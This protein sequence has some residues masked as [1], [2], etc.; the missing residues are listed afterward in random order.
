MAEH[1]S[2]MLV[3]ADD[4]GRHPSSCQ[5]LTR[6]LLD[7]HAVCWVN[8]IGTRKPKLDLATLLRGVEKVKQWAWKSRKTEAL[9]AN[10]RVVNP[11]MWPWISRR[12]DRWL[13]RKL[14]LRALTPVVQ[15]LPAPVVGVTTLPVVADLMGALP[16]QRWVYYCVDDFGQWPGLDQLP[17]RQMEEGVVKKADVLIAAGANLQER[18]AHMGRE[19]HLLTHGVDLNFWQSNGHAGV[20]PQLKELERPLVV[21]WGVVDRRMDVRLVKQLAADLR[22]GT[23]VLAGPDANPEPELLQVKRVFRLPPMPLHHLPELGREAAVL[24]MP[25][26]DLPVTRQ[27]QPLKLKE[28]LATGKPVVVRDLP[29][30]RDWADSL[31]LVTTP[32]EFSRV[33]RERLESGLPID[34]KQAR[35]RLDGESWQEK[36]RTFEQWALHA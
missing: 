26:D 27:M 17:L 10:L 35:A 9:P 2:S 21:F 8:T 33:V 4:W 11:R 31:D 7:R 14:L 32:E 3:F 28:Y 5:H 13:N 34:Q 30:N 20:I 24:I 12:F 18:L 36:A 16:V 1:P 22:Q 15:S 6:Q 29:A 25:Y 23:I 19:A